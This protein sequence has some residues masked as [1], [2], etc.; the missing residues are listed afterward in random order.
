V[1]V[2]MTAGAAQPAINNRVNR[3]VKNGINLVFTVTSFDKIDF[4]QG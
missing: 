1:G 2:F 3:K 4:T